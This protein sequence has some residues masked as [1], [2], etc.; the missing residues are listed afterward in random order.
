MVSSHLYKGSTALSSRA[1]ETPVSE[2]PNQEGARDNLKPSEM[3]FIEIP[4]LKSEQ[5]GKVFLLHNQSPLFHC[6]SLASSWFNCFHRPACTEVL[7]R[8]QI[9]FSSCDTQ[10]HM[11]IGCQLR[12]VTTPELP[13]SGDAKSL[14]SDQRASVSLSIKSHSD[15]VHANFKFMKWSLRTSQAVLW[16]VIV[17]DR[18]RP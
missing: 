4:L 3:G 1:I 17:T 9:R 18:P 14:H 12:S 5:K 11:T 16:C 8:Q 7:A 15:L 13:D 2:F 6:P 10:A